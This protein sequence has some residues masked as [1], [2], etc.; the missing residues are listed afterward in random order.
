MGLFIIELQG[1][2][3]VS[4]AVVKKGSLTFIHRC[5]TAGHVGYIIDDE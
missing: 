4:R 3:V 1:N 2:G 5:T